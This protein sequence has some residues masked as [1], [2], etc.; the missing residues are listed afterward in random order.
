MILSFDKR[1]M[2]ILERADVY[3]TKH[4]NEDTLNPPYIFTSYNAEAPLTQEE[5]KEIEDILARHGLACTF[6][7]AF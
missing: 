1:I 5:Q 3:I 6:R 2:R 7:N 4:F